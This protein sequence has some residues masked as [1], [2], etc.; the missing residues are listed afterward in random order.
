M[1]KVSERKNGFSL[2]LESVRVLGELEVSGDWQW[3]GIVLIMV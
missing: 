1:A 3:T 2:G